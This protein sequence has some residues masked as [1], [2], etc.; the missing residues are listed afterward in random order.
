MRA[1][2]TVKENKEHNQFLCN[3]SCLLT[4]QNFIFLNLCFIIDSLLNI[5]KERPH[6]TMTVLS[7]SKIYNKYTYQNK[8]NGK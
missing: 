5:T 6:L 2:I 3:I 1:C 4:K 7:D 8:K